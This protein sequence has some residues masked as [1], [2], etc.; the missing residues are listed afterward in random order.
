MY[1]IIYF[2]R[3]AYHSNEYLYYFMMYDLKVVGM[4]YMYY[5]VFVCGCSSKL[6]YSYTKYAIYMYNWL[7]RSLTQIVIFLLLTLGAHAQRGL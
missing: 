1:N 3:N 7:Q 6:H 2:S 5:Q 4:H